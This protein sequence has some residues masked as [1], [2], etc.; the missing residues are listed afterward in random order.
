VPI[1]KLLTSVPG[2]YPPDRALQGLRRLTTVNARKPADLAILKSLTADT[3]K[4]EEEIVRIFS[5]DDDYLSD[6][7]FTPI[8]IAVLD[9]YDPTDNERPSL[10]QLIEFV[11][12]ANNAAPGTDWGRWKTKFQRKS[13]LFLAIIEQYRVSAIE[14]PNTYKVIHN[15][16]DQKDR[17]FHWTPLHWASTTNRAEKMKILIENGAD[18]FIQSNLNANIIHAAV[19]SNALQSLAYALEICKCYPDRLNIDQAN[20]WGESPL[21]MAAQGCLV[22]CVRLL[23]EAGADRNIRQENQQ[24]ALHYAGLSKRGN[25][26]RA[27]VT[28]LCE[29]ENQ[30][31]A[32]INAQDEDGRSP[33]F[34]FLD[35]SEC[36][37]ILVRRGARLDLLDKTGKSVFHHVCIQDE[38]EQLRTLLRLSPDPEMILREKDIDGN[39]ALIEALRHGSVDSAITLLGYDDVGDV[40]GQGG[41]AAVHYAA[42]LG[43]PDLLEMVLKHPSFEKGLTTGDDK[44]VQ[45]VAMESGNWCG[46][47]KELV[48]KYNSIT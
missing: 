19:E 40:V 22:D 45:I 6:F 23:L 30:S 25:A 4:V 38:N 9:L 7:E 2:W 16:L 32:H 33:V 5:K 11:D 15:L 26:R 28:L 47:V 1:L 18:P 48:R 31:C 46:R 29:G 14:N 3:T 24:V 21:I 35:D 43:D 41:W 39:T 36:M 13:P 12:N 8:H 10:E 20:V 44:T 42:K 37:E 17:K 34:D 27:T